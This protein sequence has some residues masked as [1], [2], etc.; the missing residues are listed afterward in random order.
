MASSKTSAAVFGAVNDTGATDQNTPITINVLANDTPSSTPKVLKS[1]SGTHSAKGAL[2]SIV[3]G[4]VVYNPDGD[5][6]LAALAVGE[7]ATDTFTYTMT[8]AGNKTIHSY[9]HCYCN[10]RKRSAGYRGD[11]VESS[12]Y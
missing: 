5:P 7:T 10:W 8:E 6:T 11:R 3:N 1:L 2:I 12:D 4:K 9:C